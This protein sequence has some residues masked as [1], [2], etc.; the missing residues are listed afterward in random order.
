[1]K[2]YIYVHTINTS[3]VSLMYLVMP[4]IFILDLN[5]AS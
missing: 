4:G 1:M 2:V 3:S 5:K